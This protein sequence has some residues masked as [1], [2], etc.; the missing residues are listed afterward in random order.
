MVIGK[1]YKKNSFSE[2]NS[3]FKKINKKFKLNYFDDIFNQKNE[4]NK[5]T[6]LVKKSDLIIYNYSSV[7]TKNK[8]IELSKKLKKKIININKENINS[9]NNSNIINF[10]NSY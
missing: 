2:V 1:S 9:K 7:K 4:K 5:L 8:I 6:N 3:P 10:F